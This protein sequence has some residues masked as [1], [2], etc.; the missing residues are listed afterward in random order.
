MAAPQ[1]PAETHPSTVMVLKKTRPTTLTDLPEE[2]LEKIF[3]YLA[4]H[5]NISYPCDNLDAF[6]AVSFTSKQFRRI[7]LPMNTMYRPMFKSAVDHI[8]RLGGEG[9]WSRSKAANVANAGWD[10]T[11][12]LL[13]GGS[14]CPT[15]V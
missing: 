5:S 8:Q 6:L 1:K 15:G 14:S 3:E 2:L 4:P 10:A 7:V 13:Y 9:H 11:M 12:R